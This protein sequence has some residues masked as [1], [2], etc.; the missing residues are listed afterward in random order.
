M[1][2]LRDLRRTEDI[3]VWKGLSLVWLMNTP[4]PRLMISYKTCANTREQTH[5]WMKSQNFGLWAE[6]CSVVE[7]LPSSFWYWALSQYQ[8][9]PKNNNNENPKV[10]DFVS[11]RC[12]ILFIF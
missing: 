3:L 1:R 9:R 6:M 4:Q 5:G 12:K 10:L 8:K 2:E 7:C 11:E